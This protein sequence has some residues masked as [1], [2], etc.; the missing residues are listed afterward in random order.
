MSRSV[1]SV[2]APQHEAQSPLAMKH[3]P[4][5]AVLPSAMLAVVVVVVVGGGGVVVV[6]VSSTDVTPNP[7]IDF[8]VRLRTRAIIRVMIGAKLGREKGRDWRREAT[9]RHF[10][11][12]SAEFWCDRESAKREE[13]ECARGG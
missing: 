6:V 9:G 13:N 12:G 8:K 1:V 4:T 10:P 11:R 2:Q 7:W 3:S 5:P